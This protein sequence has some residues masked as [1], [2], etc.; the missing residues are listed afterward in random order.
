MVK[1]LATKWGPNSYMFIALGKNKA[2][3]EGTGGGGGG[4]GEV[5]CP[6][7]NGLRQANEGG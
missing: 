4:G 1:K 7:G 6:K 5:M 3:V 2:G